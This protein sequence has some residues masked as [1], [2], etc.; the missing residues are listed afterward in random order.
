MLLGI[1][2]VIGKPIRVDRNTLNVERG[3]F[4]RVCVEIDL[5]QPVVGK[6]C[7]DDHWFRVEYEGLH[8]ICSKC[9]C[10]G[11][12]TRN[13]IQELAIEPLTDKAH[14]DGVSGSM[15]GQESA[16]M[17]L[18]QNDQTDQPQGVDAGVGDQS[19]KKGSTV[20]TFE[21]QHEGGTK[22]I[23]GDWLIVTRRKK[24]MPKK[25][26][27]KVLEGIKSLVDKSNKEIAGNQGPARRPMDGHE[28]AHQKKRRH[29]NLQMS[30]FNIGSAQGPKGKSVALDD[31]V[32]PPKVIPKAVSSSMTKDTEVSTGKGVP[33]KVVLAKERVQESS[34]TT[35]V[36]WPVNLGCSSSMVEDR[37]PPPTSHVQDV[38]MSTDN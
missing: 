37:D 34:H 19:I 10:Y 35:T 12:M 38:D 13:C 32:P 33:P 11:H 1:A 29:G 23:H 28:E 31:K 27:K 6:Y 36:I 22:E 30:S 20:V 26:N 2:S 25:V 18:V 3:R 9:G 4:A 14:Q 16:A 24:G 8:L 7:L 17:V 15:A 21:D 5:T